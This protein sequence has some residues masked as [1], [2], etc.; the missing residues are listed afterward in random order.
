MSNNYTPQ[1]RNYESQHLDFGYLQWRTAGPDG[2]DVRAARLGF[3]TP[4]AMIRAAAVDPTRRDIDDILLDWIP[5]RVDGSAQIRETEGEYMLLTAHDHLRRVHHRHVLHRFR[6][7]DFAHHPFT[8]AGSD[9]YWMSRK[10]ANTEYLHRTRA[11]TRED[12]G[13]TTAQE[14]E[15]SLGWRGR[16]L[17]GPTQQNQPSAELL[18]QSQRRVPPGGLFQYRKLV[19]RFCIGKC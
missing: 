1:T 16:R 12:N 11:C 18:R 15:Q 17:L 5:G 4:E 10:D 14:I 8:W 19:I 13:S 6:R 3:R 7:F 2:D 9:P